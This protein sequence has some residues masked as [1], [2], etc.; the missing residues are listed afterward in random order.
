MINMGLIAFL[1]FFIS[2]VDCCAWKIVRLPLEPFYLTKPFSLSTA[3]AVCVGCLFVPI[4]DSMRIKKMLKQHGPVRYY[5]RRKLP[6]MGGL[7]FVPVGIAV[8]RG[9][10]RTSSVPVNGVAL[11]TLAFAAI[12][13]LDDIVTFINGHSYRVLRWIKFLLQVGFPTFLP[14]P[15]PHTFFLSHTRSACNT[16]CK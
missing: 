5:L 1:A 16:I 7:F 12:G 11:V 4:A 8:A 6:T 10:A 2:F 15:L 14:F 3:V 13:L 9:I